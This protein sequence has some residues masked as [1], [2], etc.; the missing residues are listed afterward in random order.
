MSRQDLTDTVGDCQGSTQ[1]WIPNSGMCHCWFARLQAAVCGCLRLR[2]STRDWST[3]YCHVSLLIICTS[4]SSSAQAMCCK[5]FKA[6]GWAGLYSRTR[7][8]L[9][10]LY[11]QFAQLAFLST[12]QCAARG[13]HAYCELKQAGAAGST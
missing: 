12:L 5:V 10:L 2:W 6:Y 8:V 11:C 13:Q 4:T 9:S 3:E 7:P 1:H